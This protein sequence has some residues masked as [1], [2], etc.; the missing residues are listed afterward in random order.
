VNIGT[1][2]EETKADFAEQQEL[3]KSQI[4]RM[5]TS[6]AVEKVSKKKNDLP[7]AFKQEAV[8]GELDLSNRNLSDMHATELA[9][10]IRTMSG[11]I[12]SLILAKNRISDEGVPVI[13][14]ALCES[15]IESVSLQANKLSDKCVEA[16]VGSLKTNKS[17]KCLDLSNNGI[18]SRLM[19]NKLKNA[20]P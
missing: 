16:V 11:H 13:V 18:Q 6:K 15:Q 8:N 4:R 9:K 5:S 14:K 3:P 10:C 12:R 1:K 7:T 20:L 2:T 19:K 17:I